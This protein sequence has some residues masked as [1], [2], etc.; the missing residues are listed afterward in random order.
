MKKIKILAIIL[1]LCLSSISCGEKEPVFQ[2]AY[3]IKSE[4]IT[5]VKKENIYHLLTDNGWLYYGE[6]FEEESK[7]SETFYKKKLGDASA[8]VRLCSVDLTT[9]YVYDIK[10]DSQQNLY[11]LLEKENGD[12]SV[13][14]ISEKEEIDIA[15]GLQEYVNTN[16]GDWYLESG[17]DG[18]LLCY[19]G[20][21]YF[22]IDHAGNVKTFNNT[23]SILS[24]HI[25]SEGGIAA[26]VSNGKGGREVC[27]VDKET[28]IFHKLK[29]VPVNS[30][31][32]EITVSSAGGFYV[33]T[34]AALYYYD[35]QKQMSE[36][37]FAWTDYSLSGK[38][39]VGV[40]EDD[41][42]NI[43]GLL[44]DNLQ[45]MQKS[46]SMIP[47][48]AEK[49]KITL[50]LG[51][52]D[53]NSEI[54]NAVIQFNAENE[55]YIILI[56]EYTEQL[57]QSAQWQT[58]ANLL[59]NDVLAGKGP[60]II[61]LD[62]D[63]LDAAL[64]AEKGVLENMRPFL[65][66]SG[67][68]RETDIQPD[69]LEVLLE[70]EKLYMLPTNFAVQ[71]FM[72]AKEMSDALTGNKV[73]WSIED[74]MELAAG[75]PQAKDIVANLDRQQ[76]MEWCLREEEIG[77]RNTG[78]REFWEEQFPK[79][80]AYSEW[81]PEAAE[82]N[83]DFSRYRRGEVL[84]N[85]IAISDMEGLMLEKAIWG[86]E[87]AYIGDP[88]AAG[89]T[90]FIPRN[91]WGIS[92]E[93]RHK[94]EAWRF[95]EYYFTQEGQKNAA[96]NWFFSVLRD[97]LTQ[98][99]QGSMANAVP[100][101]YEMDGIIIDVQTPAQ[102][103]IDAMWGLIANISEMRKNSPE[104]SDILS[105]ELPSYYAGQKSREEVTDVIRNRIELYVSEQLP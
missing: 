19:G 24:M 25:L 14:K 92:A 91:M 41:E 4:D 72:A 75:Q 85:A 88:G 48:T 80:L 15:A 18:S 33:R 54:E 39:V 101:T 22:M 10:A 36:K 84:V 44:T 20:K 2:S 37:L 81:F 49:E 5:G 52:V 102:E 58:A 53:S 96:P 9:D 61:A 51:C 103:D 8:P 23:E 73:T 43:G 21:W 1:L 32:Y 35:V 82:Y 67:I 62:T 97:K 104:I 69:I 6:I 76:F 65:A 95:I 89:G 28:G 63:Y 16:E 27:T 71:T 68:I 12:I 38:E 93:S 78:S 90:V 55:Q 77:L 11:L 94:Q 50:T 17:N 56:K 99:L 29:N 64:L 59:L 31:E 86:Q 46:F 47:G 87:T 74:L 3:Q 57:E 70:D 42:G 13:R 45:N 100:R 105:E 40:Y 34:D 66:E 60:D 26:V 79:Y 98:Q 83:P 7:L 30:Y